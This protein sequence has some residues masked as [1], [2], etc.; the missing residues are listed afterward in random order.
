M[1]N[2]TKHCVNYC[3]DHK[4]RKG[5]WAH[6]FLVPFVDEENE[7]AMNHE[8]EVDDDKEVVGVPEGVEAS[9]SVQRRWKPYNVLTEM[10]G[11]ECE[12]DGH[13]NDHRDPSGPHH[14]R[15]QPSVRRH[16]ILEI[17]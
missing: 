2:E 4:M 14:A 13:E 1:I 17:G 16:L 8:Q 11:C 7:I 5:S 9:Q 12:G 15:Y 10:T 6:R 3:V